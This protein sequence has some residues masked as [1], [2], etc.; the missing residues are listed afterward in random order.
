MQSVKIRGMEELDKRFADLLESS[1]AARRD[2]HARIAQAVE[3]EVQVQIDASGINDRG[4][5]VKSWQESRVGSGGGYAAV[6]AVKGQTGPNSPGA[7]TNYLENG[8]KIR[9]PSGHA[10]RK[11]AG[12]AK[13]PY[14]DGFHF[15]QA[16]RAKVQEIALAETQ[17][18]ADDMARE[19][20]G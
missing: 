13:K 6:S 18:L 9:G 12:R 16:A 11:R 7:I 14:V 20:E 5:R 2:L 4:G 8:H 3:R 17:K 15:Y 19:L 10:K 1:Q